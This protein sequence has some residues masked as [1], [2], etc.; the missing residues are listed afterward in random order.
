ML[1]HIT[2]PTEKLSLKIICVNASIYII[3]TIKLLIVYL[4]VIW[5]WNLNKL[6]PIF[7]KIIIDKDYWTANVLWNYINI[8]SGNKKLDI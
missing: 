4:K 8:G 2:L 5:S 1:R 7:K 3:K 6:F